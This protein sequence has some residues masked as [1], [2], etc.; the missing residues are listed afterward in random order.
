MAESIAAKQALAPAPAPGSSSTLASLFLKVERDHDRAAVMER[1]IAGRTDR[2]PDW[3]FLRHVLRMALYLR[4]RCG[5]E[6]NDRVALVAPLGPEWVVLDWAT[7]LQGATTVV[8]DPEAPDAKV[9]ATLGEVAPRVVL[10]E[11]EADGARVRDLAGGSLERIVT[12]D[13]AGTGGS[14]VSFAEA[15]DLGGTLDTAERANALRDRARAVDAS[16]P[17]ALHTAT[18]VS[19]T[20]G[21]I[22]AR[23]GRRAGATGRQPGGPRPQ[24]VVVLDEGTAVTPAL[25][26]A[27]YGYVADG[28]TCTAWVAREGQRRFAGARSND[29]EAIHE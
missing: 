2:T 18:G 11:A 8:I 3:R 24:P 25:H 20:S 4:E 27:L 23:A 19:L 22:A 12:L 10:V 9:F 14:I 16:Q 13:P 1:R 17:A 15:L 29:E 7:V 28:S 5:L 26:V 6:A 21:E